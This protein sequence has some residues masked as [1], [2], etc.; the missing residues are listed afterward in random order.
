[1][2][3]QLLTNNFSSAILENWEDFKVVDIKFN[4]YS[5]EPSYHF[6]WTFKKYKGSGEIFFKNDK[7]RNKTG[8]NYS[9]L[10]IINPR[11]ASTKSTCSLYNDCGLEDVFNRILIK[12]HNVI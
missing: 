9:S 8:D 2:S 12:Y 3:K 10:T 1:M 5:N 6:H 4:E 11:N 7:V